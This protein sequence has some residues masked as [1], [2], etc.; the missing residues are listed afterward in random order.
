MSAYVI[1]HITVTNA[2]GYAGYTARVPGTLIPH[3]GEFVVRGGE[4]TV[5]EG[6]IGHSR[7]VAIRFPDRTR[8]EAWYNSPAYQEIVPIR[9]ANS[10][11]VLMLAEGFAA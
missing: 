8:A 5:L 11:G 9:Q 2:E 4:T 1:G 6:E 3:E 7:H 10:T